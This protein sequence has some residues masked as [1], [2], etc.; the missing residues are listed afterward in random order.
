MIL[1]KKTPSY[2]NGSRVRLAVIVVAASACAASASSAASAAAKARAD[3]TP[4]DGLVVRLLAN[5]ETL[6][7]GSPPTGCSTGADIRETHPYWS[8]L[9][10]TPSASGITFGDMGLDIHVGDGNTVGLD[11]Q[12]NQTDVTPGQPDKR[13]SV[14]SPYSGPCAPLQPIASSA[15]GPVYPLGWDEYIQNPQGGGSPGQYTGTGCVA[16]S[17]TQTQIAVTLQLGTCTP[18]TFPPLPTS[19]SDYVVIDSRSS[20]DPAATISH[21]G[22]ALVR[23]LRK[24]LPGDSLTVL[25]NR[26]VPRG[27]ITGAAY[28]ATRVSNDYRN[29]IRH[30]ASWLS[31]EVK[32][33]DTTCAQSQIILVGHGEGAQLTG[34]YAQ[35]AGITEHGILAVVLFG[36]PRFNGNSGVWGTA[37]DMSFGNFPKVNGLV[38]PRPAFNPKLL[39]LSFCHLSDPACDKPRHFTRTLS[40]VGDYP[41]AAELASA[42]HNIVE[43]GSVGG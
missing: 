32:R 7:N 27:T 4:Y 17:Q 6:R 36:D 28:G 8:T 26:Y 33:L 12:L 18:A 14:Y 16:I 22:A 38:G 35:T 31:N 1:L 20:G 19:C 43:V 9:T 10:L 5:T 13:I 30:G 2:A 23:S 21:P 42:T 29:A 24:A 34:D 40:W 39:V 41:T 25:T 11:G 37:V 3:S 15:A